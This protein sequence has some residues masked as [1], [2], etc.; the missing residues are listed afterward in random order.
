ML[1]YCT[2]WTCRAANVDFG[3][4]L[5][6]PICVSS[7]RIFAL[8]LRFSFA[9]HAFDPPLLRKSI[10]GIWI[11][12]DFPLLCR[13]ILL[14]V[15][16]SVALSSLLWWRLS[17]PSWFACIVFRRSVLISFYESSDLVAVYK[18]CS[19]P[20]T[21]FCRRRLGRNFCSVAG[22]MLPRRILWCRDICLVLAMKN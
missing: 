10:Q 20:C 15:A 17:L 9:H 2:R 1:R 12:I 5:C 14:L 18:S 8:I 16:S 13:P 7:S 22:P 11:S 3:V 6:S 21:Y 4:A 19:I